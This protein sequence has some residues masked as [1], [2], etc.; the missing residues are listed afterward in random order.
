M[1]I[2]LIKSLATSLQW[3]MEQ[4]DID[5]TFL[6]SNIDENIYMQQPEGHIDSNH[7]D[8]VCK[9]QK[10]LYGLKQSA[11]LWNQLLSKTLK[12]LG[13]QQLLTDT[14]CFK[15][16][17]HEGPAIIIDVYVDDLITARTPDPIKVT[18]RDLKGHF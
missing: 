1:T 2:R 8:H 12:T 15:K 5:T 13:F 3:P 18:I 10:S 14:S 16:T 11:H 4:A 9:L 7:P 17:D 6:W